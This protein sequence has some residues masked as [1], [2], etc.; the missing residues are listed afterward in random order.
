MLTCPAVHIPTRSL[1]RSSSTPE[2]SDPL[3][4]VVTRSLSISLL[5]LSRA[6]TGREPLAGC[7]DGD[8]SRG[9]HGECCFGNSRR[10]FLGRRLRRARRGPGRGRATWSVPRTPGRPPD[11]C[12]RRSGRVWTTA[13]YYHDQYRQQPSPR[14][15][16]AA[17][18]DEPDCGAGRRAQQQRLRR[19]PP[20]TTTAATT[21]TRAPHLSLMILLQVHLQ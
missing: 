14:D 3:H 21:T 11:A 10:V 7:C 20:T 15:G 2:P 6:L 9:Q 13:W 5:Q 4:S 12:L 16:Y 17:P 19:R 8:S 18:A 1:L